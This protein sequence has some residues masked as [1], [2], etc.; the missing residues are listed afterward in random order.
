MQYAAELARRYPSILSVSLHPGAV[1]TD[2]IER[3]KPEEKDLVYRMNEVVVE[4]EEGVWNTC[5]CVTGGRGEVR[6]GEV[7]FLV[8]MVGEHTKELQDGEMCARFW[9]WTQEELGGNGL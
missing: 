2:L 1:K 8:G 5:W 7:Y 6:N 4:P 3:L 9:D